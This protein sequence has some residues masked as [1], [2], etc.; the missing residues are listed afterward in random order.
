MYE[1]RPLP[2][3]PPPPPPPPS[4]CSLALGLLGRAAEQGLPLVPLTALTAFKETD[5]RALRSGKKAPEVL[6]PKNAAKFEKVTLGDYLNTEGYSDFFRENYVVPMCAAIWS[7]SNKAE[8]C[9]LTA[10]KTML[11]ASRTVLKVP[12][13]PALETRI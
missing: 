6:E 1:P 13:V 5:G 2:S 9:R 10:S 7:C 12:M 3:P 11:T 4:D 8:R